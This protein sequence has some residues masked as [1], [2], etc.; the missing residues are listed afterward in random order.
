M[1]YGRAPWTKLMRCRLNLR[2]GLKA[3]TSR[4]C[5]RETASGTQERMKERVRDSDTMAPQYRQGTGPTEEFQ[6]LAKGYQQSSTKGVKP[7]SMEAQHALRAEIIRSG[8][9]VQFKGLDEGKPTPVTAS[10]G[11]ALVSWTR[12]WQRTMTKL[13]NHTDSCCHLSGAWATPY[14]MAGLDPVVDEVEEVAVSQAQF[15]AHES[16]WSAAA[17]GWGFHL[18]VKRGP[19]PLGHPL[20]LPS[21]HLHNS[22]LQH[23]ASAASPACIYYA[24][25]GKLYLTPSTRSRRGKNGITVLPLSSC[26]A[27]LV[28]NEAARNCHLSFEGGSSPQP[29]YDRTMRK[30]TCGHESLCML[31]AQAYSEAREGR[32]VLRHT[33]GLIW[34]LKFWELCIV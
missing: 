1:R 17:E 24:R 15:G 21:V 14:L 6:T 11:S 7:A 25:L 12:E 5:E 18:V 32:S 28:G 9:R 8:Q 10:S 20:P 22:R 23:P 31:E 3:G 16:R 2:S 30:S 27:A 29:T 33:G 4:V 26:N 19:E 13:W 34:S